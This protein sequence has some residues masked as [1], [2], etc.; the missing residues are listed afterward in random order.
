MHIPQTCTSKNKKNTAK[1]R[2]TEII[3]KIHI[4]TNATTDAIETTTQ[5]TQDTHTTNRA[6]ETSTMTDD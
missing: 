1:R 3:Y 6:N 2:L 4:N 5:T